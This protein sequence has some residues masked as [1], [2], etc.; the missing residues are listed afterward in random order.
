VTDLPDE[1]LSPTALARRRAHAAWRETREREARAHAVQLYPRDGDGPDMM[2]H[3]QAL[4]E[5][6]MYG[7]RES[8]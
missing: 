7:G 3:W 1:A 6:G 8:R 5:R 2:R 4:V